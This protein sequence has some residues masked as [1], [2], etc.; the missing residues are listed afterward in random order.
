[1]TTRSPVVRVDDFDVDV[2]RKDIKNL[3]LAVYPPLGRVRVSAPATLD[4]EAVR[5]AVIARLAWVRRQRRQIQSQERE[6][7]REMTDGE[8]HYLWGRAY[9]LRIIE[10]GAQQAVTLSGDRRL[11]LHVRPGADRQARERRL[12]EWQRRELRR[13]AHGVVSQW[14]GVIGVSEPSWAIRRMRTKWGTCVPERSR[15][16][17]NLELA[18]KP[19]ECLEYIVVHELV[20]LL[21]RNHT[22]RFYELM[23]RFMPDWRTVRETLNRLP[24]A[25]WARH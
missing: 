22:E 8:T 10:D 4:D 7:P 19:R 12:A 23:D 16:W 13:V 5:L 15:I 2:V 21:E 20:H 18:K 24:T 3:H 9:R 6:T 25:D 1:M 11:E 17:L 14:A